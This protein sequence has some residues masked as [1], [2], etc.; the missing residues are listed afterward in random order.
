MQSAEVLE[1]LPGHY[2]HVKMMVAI[3]VVVEL[4]SIY[5]F[6]QVV[7]TK[8]KKKKKMLKKLKI[9]ATKKFQERYIHN[10]VSLQ[11]WFGH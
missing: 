7:L 6:Q 4:Q 1:I 5:Q 3:I 11:W 9:M 2:I 10:E 8:S